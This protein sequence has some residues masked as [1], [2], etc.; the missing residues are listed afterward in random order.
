MPIFHCFW[1]IL[2]DVVKKARWGKNPVKTVNFG[3]SL[4]KNGQNG[5]VGRKWAAAD[6]W[7]FSGSFC[8]VLTVFGAILTI[9]GVKVGCSS[10]F[11]VRKECFRRFLVGNGYFLVIL[12]FG[13]V[14]GGGFGRGRGFWR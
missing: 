14:F 8:W 6:F 3:H 10:D 2:G 4:I 9:F 1:R 5:A 11:W 7:G 12:G 13:G